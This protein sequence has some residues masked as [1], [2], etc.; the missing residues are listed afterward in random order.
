MYFLQI[1]WIDAHILCRLALSSCQRLLDLPIEMPLSSNPCPS[2]SSSVPHFRTVTRQYTQPCLDTSV[3]TYCKAAKAAR[4]VSSNCAAARFSKYL[5]PEDMYDCETTPMN[6]QLLNQILAA[7]DNDHNSTVYELFLQTLRSQ[8]TMHS[9][10]R[11]S[12]ITRIP[13]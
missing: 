1:I 4:L 5:S 13:D 8:D 2:C 7:L 3:L 6:H 9:H 12:L 10:H 11:N